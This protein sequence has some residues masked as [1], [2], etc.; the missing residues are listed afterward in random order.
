MRR[1]RELIFCAIL[2]CLLSPALFAQSDICE[3]STPFVPNE[4]RVQLLQLQA[5]ERARRAAERANWS[6]SILP[7]KYAT[8]ANSL[9]PLC[10]FGIEVV[11]QPA[12]KLVAV[13]APKE[14][15][16]A[17]EEALKRLDVPLPVAKSVELTAYVLVISDAPQ[18]GLQPVPSALQPAVA[19]LKSI[20]PGGTLYLAD[21]AVAR[22]IDGYGLDF[23][24]MTNIMTPA[25]TIR[26][27]ADPVVHL[28]RLN[29]TTNGASFSTSVDVPVGGQ[30]VVGKATAI[31]DKRNPVVLVMT[32]RILD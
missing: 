3:E 11:P 7:V 23:R 9:K 10:I 4:Q 29:V 16:P 14:L 20:L 6:A 18:Q 24:G 21:T 8:S 28:E 13:R 5:E 26:E 1:C 25:L 30:V 15:M 32:A 27:G 19:Q 12:I 22:G 31:T 2:V 17:I